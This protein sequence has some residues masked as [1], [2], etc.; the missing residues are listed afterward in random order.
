M[1]VSQWKCSQQHKSNVSDIKD[2]N[3]SDK[4]KAVS[5]MKGKRF[6]PQRHMISPFAVSSALPPGAERMPPCELGTHASFLLVPHQLSPPPLPSSAAVFAEGCWSLS[7]WACRRTLW[8]LGMQTHRL[9]LLCKK[10]TVLSRGSL[11]TEKIIKRHQKTH[12]CSPIHYSA[13]TRMKTKEQIKL[14]VDSL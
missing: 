8:P 1:S 3:S 9:R 6:F 12:L 10:R 11:D 13:S 4:R 5:Q 14:K 7:Q 2:C